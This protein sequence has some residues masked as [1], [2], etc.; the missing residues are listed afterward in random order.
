MKYQVGSPVLYL[1]YPKGISQLLS[2]N[3]TVT[4]SVSEIHSPGG[5]LLL[6][7]GA[8]GTRHPAHGPQHTSHGTQHTTHV[9]LHTLG[10]RGGGGGGGGGGHNTYLPEPDTFPFRE[11][12]IFNIT[13]NSWCEDWKHRSRWSVLST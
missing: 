1:S 5:K 11:G 2:R 6:K 12:H 4:R 10:N 9:T 7:Q 13:P 3:N 8:P